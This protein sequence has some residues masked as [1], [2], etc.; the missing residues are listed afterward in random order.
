MIGERHIGQ[1][2]DPYRVV[3]AQGLVAAAPG[4]SRLFQGVDDQ[5]RHA[6]ALHA[7]AQRQTALTAADDQAI[8]LRFV[9]Q[10]LAGL[11]AFVGPG[12]A[13]LDRLVVDAFGPTAAA[14]LLE[15]L[16][17]E[18]G[19]H[20]G[21]GLAVAQADMALAAPGSCFKIEPA[22]H[23]AVGEARLVPGLDRHG[24]DR[25]QLLLQ[26]GANF[27][28]A[29]HRGDVPGEANEVAP[30]TFVRREQR[31]HRRDVARGQGLLE[32][33]QPISND[34]GGGR[35]RHDALNSSNEPTAKDTKTFISCITN[36]D[37]RPASIPDSP[38]IGTRQQKCTGNMIFACDFSW[39]PISPIEIDNI[40][41]FQLVIHERNKDSNAWEIKAK[42]KALACHVAV[43]IYSVTE[44]SSPDTASDAVFEA[45]L[46]D[47]PLGRHTLGR[48][49]R[50]WT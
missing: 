5:G 38:A 8:G 37:G 41:K 9:A 25:V 27:A 40:F 43:K 13:A 21:P 48:G 16:Q 32:S 35:I 26:H 17:F 44:Q 6:Q 23:H 24:R 46:C 30:K 49:L 28:L 31:G 14:G 45:P 11:F 33:G 2:V 29:I 36:S 12:R 34:L 22:L 15:A 50:G 10:G 3:Q 1:V 18:Q 47:R 19:R 42:A 4:V 39:S 20:Q 7:R